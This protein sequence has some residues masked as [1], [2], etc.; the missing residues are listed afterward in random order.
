MKN[1]QSVFALHPHFD[2]RP[3]D[4]YD[5]LQNDIQQE[6]TRM[7]RKYQDEIKLLREMLYR[8]GDMIRELGKNK[9]P[10]N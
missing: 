5:I 9:Q 8:Q 2:E 1:E 4:V 6:S 3:G 7:E 10:L